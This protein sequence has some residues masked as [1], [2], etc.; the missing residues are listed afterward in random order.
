MSKIKNIF[1][2][3]FPIL[4]SVL[5]C[6]VGVACNKNN[7]NNYESS[8]NVLSEY[9]KNLFVGN[10]GNFIVT[11]TSGQRES[12]YI[13]DGETSPLVDFG[14]LTVK[15]NYSFE[16]SAPKFVLKINDKSY[17]GELEKNPF[18]GT[19]VFDIEKQV[20]DSDVIS[21]YLEDINENL[22]L[23]CWSKSW[24]ITYKSALQSFLNKHKDNLSKYYVEDRLEGEIFIKIVSNDS[25]MSSVY[26]YVLLVCKNGDIL[27][28]LVDVNNGQ[29]I[30]N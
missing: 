18:D 7:Q 30:Q 21:L 11:F 2:T 8:I 3:I 25:K 4:I 22:N 1:K 15:F 16:K 23:T 24:N 17:E 27:A 20:N 26:W 13:M 14:V 29:I 12:N 6:V 5:F 28:S 10:G 19:F 9:R